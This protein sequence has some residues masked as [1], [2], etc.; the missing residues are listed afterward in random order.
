MNIIGALS[1]QTVFKGQ[2]APGTFSLENLADFI[3]MMKTAH[4]LHFNKRLGCGIEQQYN[5]YNSLKKKKKL[6]I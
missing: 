5:G 3:Q 2:F 1:A 4:K 6:M